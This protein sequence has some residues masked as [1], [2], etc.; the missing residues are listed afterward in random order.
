MFSGCTSLTKSPSLPA[1]NLSDFCYEHMFDDCSSLNKAS[2]VNATLLAQ[3]CCRGMFLNCK[4]LVS[5][6]VLHGKILQ[7][8]C[9]DYMF[10]NCSKLN[11]VKMLAE[12]TE[13]GY[14]YATNRYV[15]HWLYGTSNKGTFVKSICMLGLPDNDNNWDVKISC[16]T[17]SIVN[18]TNHT[19]NFNYS[20]SYNNGSYSSYSS[21]NAVLPYETSVISTF[22]PDYNINVNIVY[23]SAESGDNGVSTKKDVLWENGN[24]LRELLDRN[25]ITYNIKNLAIVIVSSPDIPDDDYYYY[26]RSISL[27][28]ESLIDETSLDEQN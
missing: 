18:L 22:K 11:Y 25:N 27:D 19:I 24:T 4:N 12:N 8:Y 6:P 15:N 10:Y 13:Q 23:N 5:A 1:K 28:D 14:R 2:Y 3:Y 7:P 16:V 21:Q 20:S 26:S 9:Y 17:P